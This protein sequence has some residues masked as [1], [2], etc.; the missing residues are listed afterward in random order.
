MSL[1]IHEYRLAE[2]EL[3]W[4]LKTRNALDEYQP[5]INVF[6]LSYH[7]DHHHFGAGT[8]PL[9]F[10][11]DYW[12]QS[13]FISHSSPDDYL[14]EL[15]RFNHFSY[16][17]Q[18]R[19][20]YL[21]SALGGNKLSQGIAS[22]AADY[23]QANHNIKMDYRATVSDAH[24]H[25]P[26]LISHLGYCYLGT[27]WELKTLLVHKHVFEYKQRPQRNEY[28]YAAAGIWKLRKDC[29]L[30]L[31]T[32]YEDRCFPP[33]HRR[34]YHAYISK[35]WGKFKVSP[36][37]YGSSVDQNC[38]ANILAEYSIFK[39]MTFGLG[40]ALNKVPKERAYHEFSLQT[41]LSYRF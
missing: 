14:F 32:L 25:S 35:A 33:H 39:D 34:E 36:G 18:F 28:A 4:E 41:D 17:H 30:G 13:R 3:D 9:G 2:I 31:G 40:Y 23:T 6:K 16:A 27:N 7:Q 5:Q 29:E 21:E 10:G 19:D 11:K 37:F 15:D 8:I 26:S 38:Q 12:M 22:L 24:W 20:L 1:G